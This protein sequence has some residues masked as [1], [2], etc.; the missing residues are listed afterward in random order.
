MTLEQVQR[1]IDAIT[2]DDVKNMLPVTV[3]IMLFLRPKSKLRKFRIQTKSHH[4]Y[5]P[6][7]S[8][9]QS[10]LPQNEKN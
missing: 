2:A 4:G 5:L 9:T 1:L 10:K 3:I 7:P 8:D 6:L